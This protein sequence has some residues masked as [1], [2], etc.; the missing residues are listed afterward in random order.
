MLN[1]QSKSAIIVPTIARVDAKKLS[2]LNNSVDSA[3]PLLKS[4]NTVKNKTNKRREHKKLNR[5]DIVN[6]NQLNTNMMENYFPINTNNLPVNT[7]NLPINTNNLPVNT[8]NLPI[9]TN[10][11]PVN[12]NNLPINGRENDS[13]FI[14]DDTKV[15]ENILYV[16]M[17]DNNHNNVNNSNHNNV[18]NYNYVNNNNHNIIP[19]RNVVPNV[20]NN[21]NIVL[22]YRPTA[23]FISLYPMFAYKGR[24]SPFTAIIYDMQGNK[25][26]DTNFNITI[27]F[28]DGSSLTQ[29]TIIQTPETSQYIIK[30]KHTYHKVGYYNVSLTITDIYSSVITPAYVQYTV[31]PD[32]YNNNC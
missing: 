22:N 23:F 20:Q 32:N 28:G 29:G 17:D 18:N 15:V 27:D 1:R 30:A 14:I 3:Q 11:F 13:S 24:S 10:N 7:N 6:D 12:A 31:L 25:Y 19:A 9:N 5:L 4:D 21:T 2:D 16:N 26:S 8:N